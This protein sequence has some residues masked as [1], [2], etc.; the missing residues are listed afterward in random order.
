VTGECGEG[1]SRFTTI[2]AVDLKEQASSQISSVRKNVRP[3]GG[4]RAEGPCVYARDR[5]T[6]YC[7]REETCLR[8]SK[9]SADGVRGCPRIGPRKSLWVRTYSGQRRC[10][11]CPMTSFAQVNGHVERQAG[12]YCKTVGSAYPGSNP[13]PATTSE[14]S[15]WPACTRSGASL[16][17]LSAAVARGGCDRAPVAARPKYVPKLILVSWPG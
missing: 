12:A 1:H 3:H 2:A 16:S 15:P 10:T 9:V 5:P 17:G 11:E 14:N 6:G 4:F 8:R 13:G 7:S